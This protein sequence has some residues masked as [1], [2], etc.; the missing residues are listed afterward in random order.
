[1]RRIGPYGDPAEHRVVDVR[2]EPG[3]Y[4]TVGQCGEQSVDRLVEPD[5]ALLDEHHYRRRS[6]PLGL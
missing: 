3:Q 1:L 5:L 4:A 6:D 2:V